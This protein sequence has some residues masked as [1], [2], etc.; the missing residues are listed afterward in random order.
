[1]SIVDNVTETI[2]RSAI[3]DLPGHSEN[4]LMSRESV[5]FMAEQ[6]NYS[7]SGNKIVRIN[8][9]GNMDTRTLR[10]KSKVSITGTSSNAAKVA[11]P[12]NRAA[13][14]SWW[15]KIVLKS[16]TGVVLEEVQNAANLQSALYTIMVDNDYRNNNFHLGF[17]QSDFETNPALVNNTVQTLSGDFLCPITV[18]GLLSSFEQILPSDYMKGLQIEIHLAPVSEV[19]LSPTANDAAA[20]YSVENVSVVVD[21]IEFS[22]T[23]QK[24]LDAAVKKGLKMNVSSYYNQQYISNATQS[25]NL[26]LRYPVRFCKSLI[27]T[28][29]SQ[30]NI[31]QSNADS[32]AFHGKTNA[33]TLRIGS[34]LFREVPEK[35]FYFQTLKGFGV[36]SD[37]DHMSC[38]TTRTSYLGSTATVGVKAIDLEKDHL[39]SI[40]GYNTLNQD[41]LL[42]VKSS[43][44]YVS[45]VTD[46]YLHFE[47]SIVMKSDEIEVLR[48]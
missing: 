45:D 17:R 26:L 8:L 35:E 29:R 37:K 18:C 12:V 11:L 47:Q 40:S 48:Q 41:I 9:S 28:Q 36:H 32:S 24:A 25:D 1:M 27:F 15:D 30:T 22:D 5:E 4:V 23:Y 43:S 19:I 46:V 14:F 34:K 21:R 6:S 42:S 44:N 31:T 20:S 3:F 39:G 16:G 10:L 7:P 33:Y 38:V 2:P 13:S